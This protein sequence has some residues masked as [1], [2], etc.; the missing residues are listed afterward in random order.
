MNISDLIAILE[1]IETQEGDI[2]VYAGEFSKECLVRKAEV[3]EYGV[4]GN[5]YVLLT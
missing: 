3:N 2:P 4:E 5:A 1:N